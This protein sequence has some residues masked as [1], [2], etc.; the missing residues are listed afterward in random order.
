MKKKI[1]LYSDCSLF[2]GSEYVVINILKN[3]ILREQ[4]DFAFAYRKHR[5]YQDKLNELKINEFCERLYPIKLLNNYHI[6]NYLKLHI[7]SHF[8]WR[9]LFAPF[10]IFELLGIYDIINRIRIRRFLNNKTFDIIHINN[11]GYPGAKTCVWFA[12]EAKRNGIRVIFQVNNIAEKNRERKLD[13]FVV[14]SVDKFLTASKVAKQ[15]L[16][17]RLGLSYR[18]VSTIPHFVDY[19]QPKLTRDAL[20]K[21]YNLSKH[22]IVVCEIALLQKRKG[23]QELIQALAK[24]NKESGNCRFVLFLIGE[25]ENLNDIKQCIVDNDVQSDV[26]LVGYKTNFIDY[27]AAADVVVL[28]SLRDEDMP[29]SLIS[30]LSLGAS[31]VSTNIAGIPDVIENGKSGILLDPLSNRFVDNLAESILLAYSNKEYYG[32]NALLRYKDKFSKCGYS[33]S[34]LKLYKSI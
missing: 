30:A 17:N 1:L 5:Y 33:N 26:F 29:L 31:I 32:N 12:H 7:H 22:D 19:T 10:Y 34:Y 25:G 3:N 9:I 11:G 18:K 8:G 14:Q 21:D 4:F 28:P 6:D 2:G 13:L 23:Q 20:L 24:L 15:A 16:C 27:M